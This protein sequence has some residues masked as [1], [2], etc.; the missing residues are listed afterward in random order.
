M[1]LHSA[2]SM[3]GSECALWF[4]W[5]DTRSRDARDRLIAGHTEWARGIARSVFLRTRAVPADWHDF[6]Q[7][8]FIGL[9]Q[10]V[11]SFNPGM[12][13][14]FRGYAIK[15]V[16]GSVFNG[17][18]DLRSTGS[19]RVE[20]DALRDRVESAL[21][22]EPDAIDQLI[23]TLGR[24]AMG[25]LLQAEGESLSLS[26]ATPYEHAQREGVGRLLRRFLRELPERERLVVELHYLQFQPFVAIA[27]F[28]GLTKG[29]I[30]QLHRQGL[31]RLRD[32]LAAGR[33]ADIM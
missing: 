32:K 11:E 31:G 14:P 4:E 24:L 9:M 19:A 18:R 25:A 21:D 22:D 23:S 27:E 29:R 28:L 8:A 3:E 12:G 13:I 26:P 5:R 30:S 1:T 7:N 16:R 10:A 15:R 17:L 20:D 2:A 6:V 33:L